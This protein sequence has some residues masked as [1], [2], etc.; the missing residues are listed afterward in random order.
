MLKQHWSAFAKYEMLKQDWFPRRIAKTF[1]AI[2][3]KELTLKVLA[4][5]DNTL[6]IVKSKVFVR[7]VAY[8]SI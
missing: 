6:T 3:V 2:L 7:A 1:Q 8:K 4:V 5:E